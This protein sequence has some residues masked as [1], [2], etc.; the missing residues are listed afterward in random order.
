[1]PTYEGQISQIKLPNGNLY[2]VKD[3]YARDQIATLSGY[4][5][6]LGV[7][8]TDIKTNPSTNP[9]T[10]AGAQ[11]TATVGDI[12]NYE[13]G[14]FIWNGAETNPQWQEFGDLSGLGAL[15]YKDNATGTFTPLGSITTK[16]FTGSSTTSTGKFTPSGS[17][18]GTTFTGASMTSTGTF[19][20]SGS[21]TV[22]AATPTGSETKNYTPSGSVSGTFTGASMTSTG[23]FTPSGSCG[24]PTV[25]PSTTPVNSVKTDKIATAVTGIDSAVK[26]GTVSNETLTFVLAVPATAPAVETTEVS[27]MTSVSVAAPSFTGTEGSVSVTGTTTGSVTGLSFAGDD[28]LIKAAF[29]GTEGNVSVTGT[30]TG[31]VSDGTFTGTEDDVSVTG[32]PNGSINVEWSGS[33]TDVTVS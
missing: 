21:N 9:V 22:T 16:T 7:T 24:A 17:I 3:A 28:V 1:M 5:K 13:S 8:T 18:S 4:T 23:T 31:S 33:S 15:A 19:T 12:V 32:T 6:Y 29:T 25:T 30:T 27:A 20:P 14:E 11:V 2:E 26:L 10:I